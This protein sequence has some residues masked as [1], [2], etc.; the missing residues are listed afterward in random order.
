[1]V[2]IVDSATR[3]RM[4]SGIRGKNT[5]PE[6]LV[7][8]ALHAHGFRFGTKSTLLPGRPD[9]VLPRWKVA[10]FVHGCFWHWH[11]CPLSKVP[12]SNRQFW[13]EKLES[14]VER[15]DLAVLV[16]VALGWR[17]ATI[18]ECALRGA[19]ARASFDS[20][21]DQ[22]AAWIRSPGDEPVLEISGDARP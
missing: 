5:L 7:R 8:R 17:V 3:S 14:N 18:W 4:M 10:V 21:M 19:R 12:A 6:V 2:D 9:V 13:Q 20:A 11:G 15:D 1:M 22:L 16:L